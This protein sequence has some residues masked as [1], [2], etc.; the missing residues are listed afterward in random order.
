[1]EVGEGIDRADTEAYSISKFLFSGGN[2]IRKI[3]R[4][5]TFVFLRVIDLQL[6]NTRMKKNILIA[7]GFIVAAVLPVTLFAATIT[8]EGFE[9]ADLS[10]WTSVGPSWVIDGSDVNSGASSV[11]VSGAL[12]ETSYIEKIVSTVG[13]TNIGINYS[14]KALEGLNNDEPVDEVFLEWRPNSESAWELLHTIDV[15]SADGIWHSNLPDHPIVLPASANNNPTVEIQFGARLKDSSKIVYLDDI[16]VTGDDIVVVTPPPA[17]SPVPPP[18]PAPPVVNDADGDS[19]SDSTDN[20]KSTPNFDQLDTDT[21]GI[22]DA[23]DNTPEKTLEFCTDGVDNDHN[24]LVDIADENCTDYRPS[25]ISTKL[26]TNNI[27]GKTFADFLFHWSVGLLSGDFSMPTGNTSFS[28]PFL[29]AFSITEDPA[30]GY[31]TTYSSGCNG[32]LEINKNAECTITN[33]G[34]V[35]GGG[36]GE[37]EVGVENTLQLCTDGFDN[38]DNDLID[39]ADPSCAAFQGDNEGNGNQPPALFVSPAGGS[40]NFD[41]FGCINPFATN[42]NSL[43]NKDDGSC[44]LP[45]GGDANIGASSG[46][47][48]AVGGEVLG[49]STT[50]EPSLPAGCSAYLTDYLKRGKNNDSEQ[51]KLLQTFLNENMDAKLPVTGIFGNMTKSWVKKFQVK[52]HDE[53]I[54]PWYSAGYKGKD[55]ENGTG[56]VYK[57]TKYQINL[58]K[59]AANSKLTETAPDLTP[60][61]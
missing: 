40:S 22:G 25:I 42:Y 15:T 38:N 46:S 21:N 37:E 6:L 26:I 51:V 60:D 44:K 20:C 24:G 43:A 13:Y 54:K 34:T 52:H 31:V 18:P 19:I 8:S 27:P 45:Q 29:G 16:N 61:L 59:C 57:T 30:E 41:Y 3:K 50:T 33:D 56:Y 48:G 17:P 55:I 35:T 53:I 12:P 49:A 9:T 23:C 7:F 58:M 10:G 32:K 5:N 28:F 11:K 14:T 47:A 36:D 4:I 1:M 39:A 2:M